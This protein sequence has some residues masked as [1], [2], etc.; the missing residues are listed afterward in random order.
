VDTNLVLDLFLFCDPAVGTL[1]AAL[2]RGE[3]QWI[4]TSAMQLEL[5]RVLAYPQIAQALV[6]Q[7]LVADDV[8]HRA[9]N[10]WHEVPEP[11]KASHGVRCKDRDDQIFVDLAIAHEACLLSKDKA[12]LALA[13]PLKRWNVS[14]S[15]QWE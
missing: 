6:R 9:K 11:P 15:R 12:V 3:L 10:H 14:V 5:V 7:N 2:E 8:V 1:T 13:R 4:C